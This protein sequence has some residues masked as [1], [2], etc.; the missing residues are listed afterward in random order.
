MGQQHGRDLTKKWLEAK[1]AA[2]AH[3]ISANSY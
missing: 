1:N 2:N 3:E